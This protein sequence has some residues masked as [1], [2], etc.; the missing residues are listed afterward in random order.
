L[1]VTALKPGLRFQ[2]TGQFQSHHGLLVRGKKQRYQEGSGVSKVGETQ[3][4][5]LA[6]RLKNSKVAANTMKTVQATSHTGD[7]LYVQPNNSGDDG[8][9]KLTSWCCYRVS[10]DEI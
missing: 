7:W 2:T 3:P 1:V 4:M 6:I 9:I 8:E 5:L 10:E